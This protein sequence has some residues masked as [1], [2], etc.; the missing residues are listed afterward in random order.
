MTE[1]IPKAPGVYCLWNKITNQIYVGSAKDL[2]QRIPQHFSS[3]CQNQHLKSS[4]KK[5]GKENFSITWLET[6]DNF[7]E[8]EQRLLDYV[9][10]NSIPTFNI[11]RKAGGGLLGGSIEGQRLLC[12]V[13][14]GSKQVPLFLIDTETR[15]ITR[16]E[17]ACTRRR[18]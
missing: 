14:G 13:G 6:G 9:F 11:S 1:K 18:G 2:S 16:L 12:E 3:L 17:S 8:E 7:I 15:F 5:Y 4:I 10:N